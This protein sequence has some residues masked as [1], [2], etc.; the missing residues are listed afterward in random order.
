MIKDREDVGEK[1]ER[2]KVGSPRRKDAFSAIGTAGSCDDCW[3]DRRVDQENDV[4]IG[5]IVGRLGMVLSY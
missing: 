2:K 3:A 4:V 5:A 1:K